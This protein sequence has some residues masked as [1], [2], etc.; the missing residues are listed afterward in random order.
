MKITH[1]NGVLLMEPAGHVCEYNAAA[2]TELLRLTEEVLYA[3]R[4]KELRIVADLS[5]VEFMN[6]SGLVQL[7]QAHV[8]TLSRHGRFALCCV[9]KR[10]AA[11]LRITQIERVLLIYD[12]RAEALEA[13]SYLPK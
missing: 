7:I 8:S 2:H 11:L 10:V 3:D 1:V 13:L 12:T 4:R 5:A 9:P 6:S